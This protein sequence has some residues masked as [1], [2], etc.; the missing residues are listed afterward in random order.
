MGKNWRI[1][2]LFSII[3]LISAVNL[4]PAGTKEDPLIKADRLIADQQYDEAITY[5]SDFI[6]LY[7]DRFDAAQAKI[8]QII[9]IRTSY[10]KSAESLIESLQADPTN[11]EKKLAM[12]KELEVLER[13]P[14]PAVKEFISKTK[15]LALFTY[16]KAKMEGIFAEGR[17]L[18]DA[19]SYIAAA[20]LYKSGFELY[21]PEFPELGF[22]ADIVNES[23]DR[24]E[25]VSELITAFNKIDPEMD[26]S[27]SKL[28]QAYSELLQPTD[29]SESRLDSAWSN[30]LDSALALVA[31]R[32]AIVQEGRSLEKLFNELSAKDINLTDSFFIPFAYRFIL[33][34]RTEAKVEGI[35]GSLDARWT[36][37][38]GLAQT[39]LD[40]I[41]DKLL[42]DA[43]S[44]FDQGNWDIAAN[45]LSQ[46]L[47]C[48]GR[49]TDLVSLWASYIPSDLMER[50]T[51]LGQA[52]LAIKGED[53][54][55][56]KHVIMATKSFS[57]LVAARSRLALEEQE[58]AK[59]DPGKGSVSEVLALY[60]SSREAF[61]SSI[62]EMTILRAESGKNA[63]TLAGWTLAGFAASSSQPLQGSLDAYITGS[64]GLA[65]SLEARTVSLA[66]S[67]QYDDMEKMAGLTKQEQEKAGRYIE[68]LPSDDPLF[69]DAIFHYPSIALDILKESDK[70]LTSLRTGLS[71]LLSSEYSQGEAQSSDYSPEYWMVKFK[72]LSLDAEKYSEESGKLNNRANEL[73][74]LAESNRLEAERRVT[75][76]RTAIRANDFER[77]R[78]RLE[79]AREKYSASLV[80]EQN[81]VLREESDR[82]L[83]EL[84]TAILKAEN[85]LVVADVRRLLTTGKSQYL[86]GDFDRSELTLL[87]ARARWSSTNSGPEVEVEYWLKLVQTA[88]A[89]KTGRDIPVTAPLYPEM[90]QLLSLAKQYFEEGAQALAKKDK[91]GATRAFAQAR[92]KISEVKVA[93]PLNQEARVLELKIDQLSDPDEFNKSFSR[94]FNAAVSKLDSRQD[95]NTAYSD[96]KDLEAINAR[97]PGLTAQVQR[98]EILLGFRQQPPDPKAIAE[99]KSLVQAAQRIFDSRQVAQFAF[100]KTQ[101]DR[102]ISLDPNNEAAGLLKDKIVTYIGGDTTIVLSTAAESLYNEAVSFFT[103]GDYLNARIKISRLLAVFPKGLNMQKVADLDTRLK[104]R[105]Y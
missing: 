20:D 29:K 8:R 59:I 68:G 47:I 12:I 35:A 38:I 56:Y 37:S 84:A 34:R 85:D 66:Y 43:F 41:L 9:K 100:A 33:G 78:E 79:R 83:N 2:A 91:P 102:A 13:N 17:S 104:A 40:S 31:T 62:D 54:L 81:Q 103:K 16:N 51:S 63:E 95:L 97:Y 73:R 99:A 6:K 42:S 101:L 82:V 61:V 74:R 52:A 10:N 3:F 15:D 24:V 64:I 86:Q 21:R 57:G 90:S 39:E 28:A 105:G 48:A 67:L 23:F 58:L 75:E 18:I 89:V 92:Q 55:R 77:A 70:V 32:Q 36:R 14:N 25:R 44:A 11:Q 7:P 46:A 26:A 5:L 96:L 1:S 71:S 49:G 76:S 69:P 80:S 45:S 30:A 94:M 19:G 60:K 65:R 87:Q 98:V 93:F 27:F 88:L 72:S 4:W 22:S 53:Y 50:S